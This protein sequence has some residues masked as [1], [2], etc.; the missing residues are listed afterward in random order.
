MRIGIIGSGNI[1]GTLARLWAGAGH[2]VILANSR[3][4]ESLAGLVAEIGPAASAATPAGAAEAGEV[5]VV[6]IPFLR[7]PD[8]PAAALAGKIV[9][10]ATNYYAGRDGTFPDIEAGRAGSSELL[11]GALPGANVVKAFNTIHYRHLAGDGVPPGTAGRRAIPI[12]GDDPAAKAT[13]AGLID[14]IG[15][16]AYDAGSLPD[17]RRF[18]PGTPLFNVALTSDEVAAAL[19]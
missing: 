11:A 15:F 16:D 7:Y 18:E 13:V 9:V 12:A 5:V 17:G 3:G 19:A 14:Q 2:E 4:P 10:D 1:G 6:A 8:L